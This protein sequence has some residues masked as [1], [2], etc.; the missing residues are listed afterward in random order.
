MTHKI[1]AC[2]DGSPMAAPIADAAGWV[3]STLSVP[4]TFIHVLEPV[5]PGARA[6]VEVTSP[7][8]PSP[9]PAE[10]QVVSP[11]RARGQQVL[12]FAQERL[13]SAFNI[14][15]STR[16]IEGRFLDVV[17]D[18]Q[19]DARILIVGKRGESADNGGLGANLTALIRASHRPTMIVTENFV[20]PRKV[21]LAFD[22]S[23]AMVKAVNTIAIS[24][25]FKKLEC[26]VVMVGAQ[27]DEHA[28]QMNWAEK[29]LRDS[30]IA[31]HA[32]LMVENDF[33]SALNR[34]ATDF[35]I[36]LMVM[37]AYSHNPAWQ[38]IM[39]SKTAKLLKETRMT[40]LVLR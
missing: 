2:L 5:A 35:K 26:H 1:I 21:M 29:T 8:Q 4:L 27:T 22:G 19:E 37:G 28:K 16:L 38:L 30:N 3:S 31:T 7:D 40:L 15:A 23:D 9:V 34:Y 13:R 25:I 6:T 36:D 10:G 14:E 11:E 33:Q 17:R 20:A 12:E 32:R 18:A 24:P 39:G